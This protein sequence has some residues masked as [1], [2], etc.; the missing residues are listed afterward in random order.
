MIDEL[1]VDRRRVLELTGVSTG[2]AVAGCMGQ[3]DGDGGSRQVAVSLRP[4][5]E[6]IQ[7]RQQE[8]QQEVLAGNTT[9]QEA[10]QEMQTLQQ[11]AL[12]DAVDTAEQTFGELG[13]SIE[14]RLED[15]GLL[16][17]S[18]SDGDILDSL[19]E[20]IVQAIAAGSLF[21]E[22]QTAQQQ[23]QQQQQLQQSGD[24]D[25]TSG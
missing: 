5:Q 4:D 2:V 12:A 6:E 18:G 24:S 23:Q 14:D 13:L 21:E 11:E 8:L 16:L 22:A 20:D 19:E 3:L 17:V 25:D 15:Q 9:R 1:T 10:Q 7:T